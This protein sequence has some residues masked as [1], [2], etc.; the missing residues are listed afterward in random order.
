[1]EAVSKTEWLERHSKDEFGPWNELYE[2][3]IK[4]AH[5]RGYQMMGEIRTVSWQDRHYDFGTLFTDTRILTGMSRPECGCS[6]CGS[7]VTF[8][9]TQV[10]TAD[11]ALPH[12]K[13]VHCVQRCHGATV[14]LV[15]ELYIFCDHDSN[16]YSCVDIKWKY[17]S[18]ND[19]LYKLLNIVFE[20]I[21]TRS[22]QQEERDQFTIDEQARMLVDLVA[23]R[24]RSFAE[25]RAKQIRN[26]LPTKAQLR[27]NMVLYEREQKWIND[28]V[29]MD[30]E[31]VNDSEQ[32]AKSSK[33]RSRVDHDKEGVKKQKLEEDDAEKEELRACLDIV[34]VDDISIDVESLATKYPI[35]D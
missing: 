24:K 9:Q 3:R 16:D 11:L 4:D 12:A 34:P 29:P 19:R 17:L 33:K 14:F 7:F 18:G 26:K 32:Q 15:S 20:W 2:E 30:S 25:Q 31:E 35:I 10:V 22:L 21:K 6:Q 27:N 13:S 23:E 1:M 5:D 28:F 8:K